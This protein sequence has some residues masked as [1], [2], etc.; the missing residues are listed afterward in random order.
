MSIKSLLIETHA[1]IAAQWHPIRNESVDLAT[2]GTYS[3]RKVWW[4]HRTPDG[5]WHEWEQ[6]VRNRTW[7]GSGCPRCG[8]G[9]DPDER[10]RRRSPRWKALADQHPQVAALFHPTRNAPLSASTVGSGSPLG[11]WWRCESG[12]EWIRPVFNQVQ[13]TKRGRSCPACAPRLRRGLSVMVTHPH[14][15]LQWHPTRN[16]GIRPEE[17]G[18]QSL[19]RVWW[20]GPCGHEWRATI[21][22]RAHQGSGCPRCRA[23]GASSRFDAFRAGS[24]PSLA[25]RFP[26]IAAEW[27]PTKNGDLTP[28]E[29]SYGSAKKVW[30]RCAAGHEWESTVN[31][32]TDRQGRG[33]WCCAYPSRVPVPEQIDPSRSIATLAP[34]LAAQWHPSR[35]GHATPQTIA[36]RS[37]QKVWWRCAEGHTW[38]SRPS[39]R[40]GSDSGCRACANKAE[41]ARRAA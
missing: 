40:A 36:L 11:L 14:L 28:A 23:E 31:R 2:I 37:N 17:H 41:R 18:E 1:E 30:W 32:R 7:A 33:C 13:A 9:H 26:D 34:A 38:Q 21:Q 6:I 3:N 4:A 10:A 29:V 35:N 27:H 15:I 16:E 12:H 5:G 25:D 24:A 22:S 8:Q 20:L 19:Q 39:S